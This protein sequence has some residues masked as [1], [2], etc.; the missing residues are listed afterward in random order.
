MLF[1]N[2]MKLGISLERTTSNLFFSLSVMQD[3]A[4]F[5][6]VTNFTN[7]RHMEKILFNEI[8]HLINA[9]DI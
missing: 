5:L 1:D 6:Y 2:F 3:R 4:N 9:I 8:R 7:E